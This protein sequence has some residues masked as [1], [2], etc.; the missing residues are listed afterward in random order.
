MVTM[1]YVK[2]DW[3]SNE[4]DGSGVGADDYLKYI[5]LHDGLGEE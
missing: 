4:K 2:Y 3:D 5:V 1:A